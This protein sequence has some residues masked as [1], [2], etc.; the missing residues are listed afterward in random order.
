MLIAIQRGREHCYL[1][2]FGLAKSASRTSLT[3]TGQLM[4]TIDYNAEPRARGARRA[5]NARW[6]RDENAHGPAHVA[7]RGRPVGLLGEPDR[8]AWAL[9]L[10]PR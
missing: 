10:T 1:A 3:A 4:G 6:A 8:Y 7:S 9:P 5:R 2:D